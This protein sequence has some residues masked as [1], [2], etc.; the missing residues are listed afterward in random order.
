MGNAFTL[1]PQEWEQ[2]RRLLDVALE[3]PAGERARWLDARQELDAPMRAR[4]AALLQLHES[5]AVDELMD[6]LPHIDDPDAGP[7]PDANGP[8][9]GDCVGPY[10]L[11]RLLGQGGMGTVWLAQ[12]SDAL[13]ERAVALKLPRLVMERGALAARMARERRILSALEHDGIARLYD[14]GIDADDRPYLALEYVDGTP[15]DVFCDA[16]ALDLRARLRLFRDVIDVVAYAH[17]RLVV[18]RDLKPANVLVTSDG[19]VK[20]LDFGIGKLLDDAEEGGR[21][22]TLYAGRP[23]TIEFASPEQVRGEAIG[24]ASDIYS[25]G[26]MLFHLLT[27]ARPY[28][29]RRATRAALEEAVLAGE[30]LRASAATRSAPRRAELRGDLDTIIG[31]ALQKDPAARY[32]T[33]NAFSDDIVRHLTQRPVRA[34]P[35]RRAYRIGK[36]LRRNR[37]AVSVG[38]VFVALAVVG[39]GAVL[40]QAQVALAERSRAEAISSFVLSIFSEADPYQ[41]SGAPMSAVSLLENAHRR[42]NREVADR[43]RMQVEMLVHV[44]ESLVNLHANDDAG[45]AFDEAVTLATRALGA[46]HPL[47]LRARTSRLSVLRFREDAAGSARELKSLLPLLRRHDDGAMLGDALR[48][49]AHLCIDTADYPGAIAAAS[50]SLTLVRRRY[51]AKSSLTARAA[52]LLALALEY[53]HRYAEAERHARDAVAMATTAGDSEGGDVLE[54]RLI[55]ARVLGES[56]RLRPAIDEM[57]KSLAAGRAH[58]GDDALEV[59]F[60]E[61]SLA[62]Y[63]LQAGDLAQAETLAADVVAIFDKRAESGG[64]N[65]QFAHAAHAGVVLARRDAARALA[66]LDAAIPKLAELLP[67]AHP[68]LVRSR[69][70]KVQAL[71]LAGSYG[72]AETEL[73]LLPR[74][75]D[76]G[77]LAVGALGARATLERVQGHAREAEQSA[78]AALERAGALGDRIAR[79]RWLPELGFALTASGRPEAARAAFDEALALSDELQFQDSPERADAWVGLADI[80]ALRGDCLEAESNFRR[81]RGYWAR[82]G[83][84]VPVARWQGGRCP[85]PTAR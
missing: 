81:A 84:W 44:G 26:V 51:G 11:E 33:A 49:Q 13:I 70:L 18:H 82:V 63:L 55:L 57:R 16:R 74:T 1:D 62:K 48:E 60:Y 73:A 53:A 72:A 83:P 52:M 77:A 80:A 9:P 35:D 23:L 76:D 37:V 56:G 43:P 27:G 59:G 61:H 36:F 4:L 45:R 3:L 40:W 2:L 22:L 71:T 5:G 34:Q 38:G 79:L 31:K 85:A 42:V 7:I 69:T 68:F 65:L 67:P 6:S 20:L 58:F 12:R 46:E 8:R 78:R 47:T 29:P 24:T 10:R 17:G 19:R 66:E 75:F 30:P 28:S 64:A 54:A 21:E 50:E 25:L 15:I 32:A 39:V 41:R 14:A